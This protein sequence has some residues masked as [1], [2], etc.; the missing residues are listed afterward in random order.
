MVESSNS[1]AVGPKYQGFDSRLISHGVEA[2][3][4][5]MQYI[6]QTPPSG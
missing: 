4:A 2:M 5:Q 3:V 6:I 1:K